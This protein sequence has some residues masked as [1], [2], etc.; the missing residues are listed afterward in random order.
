MQK[1]PRDV[2]E[3]VADKQVW[4]DRIEVYEHSYELGDNPTV[5]DGAPLTI[6]WKAQK[7]SEFNLSYYE[8]YRPSALRKSRH[9]LRLSVTDRARL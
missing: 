9:S 7:A 2:A 3:D 5:S 6:A 4:F 8:I 1:A